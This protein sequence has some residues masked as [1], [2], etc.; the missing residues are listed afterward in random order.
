MPLFFF[1][2][3]CVLSVDKPYK[4][5]IKK[6]VK[7]LLLPYVFFILLSCCFYWML[8][9]LSHRFTINHLWSL[10]DLFPYDN[11]II[12]TPLWFFGTVVVVFYFIVE[13]AEKYEVS[14]PFFLG[15]GIGEMIY[16][17][18]GFFFYKRGYVFQ[19][20]R[21]KKSCQVYLFLLSAI[22]FVCLFYCAEKIYVDKEMLFRIIH[23]FTA[24]SGI[25]FILMGAILCAVLS[26]V[27]VKVLCYL[28]RN[29]LYIFAVHLPLL[30]FARPIGKY[31]IG[32]NGLGYDS[33]VF[34]TDLVLAIIVSWGLKIGKDSFSKKLPHYSP[35]GIIE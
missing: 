1:L 24:I 22:A 34:L 20:Y 35:T 8:L 28:G 17:H 21:L 9:L 16:M 7:Q 5:I 3:G 4:E 23:L 25:F 19:L 15:R 32:S 11:E 27:F 18:L 13:L 31:V 6:K 10:V 33:I 14:L 29:T 12:N 26:G 30:E 2:S